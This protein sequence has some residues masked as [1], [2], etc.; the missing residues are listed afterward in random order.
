MSVLWHSI[1]KSGR[2]ICETVLGSWTSHP[3]RNGFGWFRGVHFGWIKIINS[4]GFD[5]PGLGW[6]GLFWVG[7]WVQRV[8]LTC[9]TTNYLDLFGV[10]VSYACRIIPTHLFFFGMFRMPMLK[11][12]GS[13]CWNLSFGTFFHIAESG[14]ILQLCLK[15]PG[16]APGTSGRAAWY[17]W[18][19]GALVILVRWFAVII[20]N[21]LFI[22][23]SSLITILFFSSPH[24][25][26]TCLYEGNPNSILFTVQEYK[27]YV[28]R[29]SQ[30]SRTPHAVEA[31]CNRI[32]SL[33]N[34]IQFVLFRDIPNTPHAHTNTLSL[35]LFLFLAHIASH[36]L[37]YS[38]VSVL[39]VQ[40][41]AQAH[42]C[43]K[44][45]YTMTTLQ[46][47]RNSIL[48]VLLYHWL[49]CI[50]VPWTSKWRFSYRIL[51]NFRFFRFL[52]VSWAMHGNGSQLRR[53]WSDS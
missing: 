22:A 29:L 39:L 36:Y 25:F 20:H 46:R 11:V 4:N 47:R 48:I 17:G 27:P 51:L 45:K 21:Y 6:L 15:L 28:L 13:R 30:H 7:W 8:S 16:R 5:M 26:A 52:Y 37:F 9:Q 41:P 3:P 43:K 49:E 32:E 33:S 23:S 1:Y 34:L 40:N 19:W 35:S 53:Q 10:P 42:S 14:E 2:A 38:T 44:W 24:R 50:T 18:C 31:P 12:R